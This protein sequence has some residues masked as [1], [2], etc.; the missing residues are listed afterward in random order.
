M[1]FK[2]SVALLGVKQLTR[3][4]KPE[5][6]GEPLRNWFK[7]VTFKVEGEAKK[8]APVDMGRLRSSISTDV[9]KAKVPQYATIGSNLT[10]APFMEFGTGTLSDG[11]GGSNSPHY[12]PS[13]ALDSWAARHGID[14][15]FIVARAI[16]RRGGLKPRR[17]LRD[18]VKASM[19][20][21]RASLKAMGRDIGKRF[22]KGSL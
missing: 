16:G 4:L 12:P 18:G 7:R 11:P 3:V 5:T 1:S 6:I 9:D 2:L 20:F 19:P 17:F 10:Y 8:R 14:S 22:S 21:A 15:G 13:S